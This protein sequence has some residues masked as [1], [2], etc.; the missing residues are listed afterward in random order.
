MLDDLQKSPDKPSWAKSVRSL[1]ES[2][3]FNHVWLEQWVGDI[4]ISMCSFRQRLTDSF[5]QMWNEQF[6]N[7]SWAKAYKLITIFYLKN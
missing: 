3:G 5:I 4:D 7:S 1:L 6:E 2:F